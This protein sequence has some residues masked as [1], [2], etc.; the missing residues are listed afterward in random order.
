MP[1]AIASEQPYSIRDV[2]VWQSQLMRAL[3]YLHEQ[4][5]PILHRDVK[6]ANLLLTNGRK[7]LLLADFGSARWC[8][9]RHLSGGVGTENFAAPEVRSKK[10]AELS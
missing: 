10:P 6:P 4:A 5:P 8:N 3:K 1:L 7:T 2:F 9:T